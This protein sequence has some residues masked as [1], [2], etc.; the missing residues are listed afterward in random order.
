MTAA[1]LL[2]AAVALVVACGLFVAAEFAFLAVDRRAVEAGVEQGHRRAV[3]T[4]AALRTL[5]TQLSGVQ[6]GITLT[7]LAIGFLAEPAL[8]DLFES[9]LGGIGIPNSGVHGVALV[10][11]LVISTAATMVFGELVPKNL[12][13]AKPLAV[14]YFV[15]APVRMFTRAMILPIRVLNGAANA[16]LHRFGLEAQE[17]LASARSADELLFVVQHSAREGV[18][19]A[20]T[21]TL[22]TRTLAFGDRRA[23]HAMTPRVDVRTVAADDPVQA[24]IDAAIDS[25]YS[26]FPVVAAGEDI[27]QIVGLVHLKAA[28]GVAR[29]ER[30]EILVRDVMVEPV[31][32]PSVLPF[33]PL[34]DVLQQRGLQMAVVI[35]E[36]GGTD[37]I[38]TLEDLVEELVGEVVDEFDSGDAPDSDDVTVDADN[39]FLVPGSLR[40]DEAHA[41]IGLE[42]PSGDYATVA[43]LFLD[44]FTAIPVAGDSVDVAGARWTVRE[45]DGH[46]IALLHVE[47]IAPDDEEDDQ[48]DH[49]DEPTAGSGTTS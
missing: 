25:G 12:A 35:D 36:F 15:E 30:R 11:A 28:L 27:D 34:L 40:P 22:L 20:D 39:G 31:L 48:H 29:A 8:A 43:G 13:I 6:V 21:A 42:V 10:L 47:P 4:Q 7:N 14:A 26:R 32:V 23:E 41:A 19:E 24:V 9:P 5:S 3:G 49:H 17:E 16:I 18:L 1:L 37:G 2:L 46:R 33:D 38:I 44:R 45:M